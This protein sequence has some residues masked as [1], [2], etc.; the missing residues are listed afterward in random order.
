MPNFAQ[1]TLAGHTGGDVD[2]QYTQTGTAR[3]TVS[4]AVNTGYG[5]YQ[6]ASWYRIQMFGK[7]AE[8]FSEHVKKGTAVIVSGEPEIQ[9]WT[10][11]NENERTTVQ[12]T[13][14]KWTFAGSRGDSNSNYND[15]HNE[16]P[17]K[18]KDIPF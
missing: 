1:I 9:L 3:A 5:D 13:V 18:K 16:L 6:V 8:A 14:D 17:R 2:L 7:R 11:K 10:D 12:V 4:L 15:D